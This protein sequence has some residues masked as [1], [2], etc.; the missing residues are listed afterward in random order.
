[1]NISD[2]LASPQSVIAAGV[3]GSLVR[4]GIKPPQG[5]ALIATHIGVGA[6]TAIFVAPAAVEY[7][8]SGRSLDWQRGVAFVAGFVGPHI[9]EIALR[10]IDRRGDDVGES[11]LDRFFPTRSNEDDKS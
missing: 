2:F 5:S 1:M 11:L 8:S 9:A 10:I 6:L 3:S 7:W 4:L